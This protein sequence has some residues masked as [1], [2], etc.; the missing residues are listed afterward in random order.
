MDFVL[1]LCVPFEVTIGVTGV[2]AVEDVGNEGY[3]LE[4]FTEIQGIEGNNS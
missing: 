3:G 1:G 4:I 2:P